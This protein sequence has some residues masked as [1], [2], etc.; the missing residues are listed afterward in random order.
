M[1]FRE[2]RPCFKSFLDSSIQVQRDPSIY[3]KKARSNWVEYLQIHNEMSN[4]TGRILFQ[5]SFQVHRVPSEFQ[6][7]RLKWMFCFQVQ[8]FTFNLQRFFSESL[9][10]LKSHLHNFSHALRLSFHYC[11]EVPVIFNWSHSDFFSH[12]RVFY[13]IPHWIPDIHLKVVGNSRGASKDSVWIRWNAIQIKRLPLKIK[14]R[15]PLRF[16]LN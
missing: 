7:L 8:W 12:W 2:S 3:L 11:D 10:H 16:N 5:N 14:F 15:L 6:G 13:R 1:P 9:S 4:Q